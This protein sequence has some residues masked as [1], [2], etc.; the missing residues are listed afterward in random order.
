MWLSGHK[1]IK[2]NEIDGKLAKLGAT[3]SFYGIEPVFGLANNH[4]TTD[5]RK[6]EN[7]TRRKFQIQ[8]IF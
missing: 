4:L 7:T 2:G 3:A 8:I 1:G 5:S 6:W